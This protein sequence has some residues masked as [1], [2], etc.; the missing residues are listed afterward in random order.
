MNTRWTWVLVLCGLGCSKGNSDAV[1]R[2]AATRA[3]ANAREGLEALVRLTNGLQ[4]VLTSAAPAVISAPPVRVPDPA[5][6]AETKEERPATA[7]RAQ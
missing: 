6:L 1:G 2:E 5:R 3:Q 7:R 4:T